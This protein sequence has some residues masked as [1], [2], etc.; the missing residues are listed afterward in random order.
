MF[1]WVSQPAG[2]S[3]PAR[4]CSKRPCWR[5]YAP[6]LL[7]APIMARATLEGAGP[8][9][10]SGVLSRREKRAPAHAAAWTIGPCQLGH[11]HADL[12]HV[13]MIVTDRPDVVW[14]RMQPGSRPRRMV[15][16]GSSAPLI[17][18]RMNWL[19]GTQRRSET[20]GPP[21]NRWATV[22]DTTLRASRKRSRGGHA[23]L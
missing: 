4:R 2:K 12:A 8:I 14:V 16:V 22:S 15:G 9:G 20:T 1:A 21:S 5:P 18:V 23:S 11:P 17:V 13:G 7:L 10:A 6:S 3:P 19:A